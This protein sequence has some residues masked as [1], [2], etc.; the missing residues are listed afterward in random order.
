MRLFYCPVCGKEEIRSDD[1]Y[2]NE[3]T[4]VNIRGGFGRTISHYKCECGNYLAGSMSITDGDEYMI[5]HCKDTIRGYNKGGC[6]YNCNS[7]LNGDK[8]DLLESAKQ[9]YER[10]KEE[11]RERAEALLRKINW[12]EQ[13]DKNAGDK[14]E[15]GRCKYSVLSLK[16]RSGFF[17]GRER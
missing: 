9:C 4:I 11:A 5:Q 3:R 13:C 14:C 2:R 1:P 8:C 7:S 16:Q 10:R 6:Y 12:H 15:H 17:C